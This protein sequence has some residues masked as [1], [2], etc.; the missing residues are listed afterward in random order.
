VVS[1]PAE[2]N[3][4]SMSLYQKWT[5]VLNFFELLACIV[6]FANWKKIK[7]TYWKWFPVYLAVIVSTEI[8][9]E[10]IGNIL[11]RKD[12]NAHIYYFFSI[13]L[14]FIF[15]FWLFLRWSDSGKEKKWP[16][17][18]GAI[19]VGAWLVEL[20]FLQESQLAFLSFSYTIGNIVLL[21]LILKFFI[22]FINSDRILGYRSEAMFWVCL[23][24]LIFYLMTLPFFG[25]WNTMNY[26]YPDFFNKYWI[27]QMAL[28]CLMYLLFALAFI[29]G[30]WKQRSS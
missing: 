15:F 17:I 13:P 14:Q 26:K 2:I 20:L 25:L 3:L 29:L 27:V 22:N 12:I 1:L 24:L 10:Y 21:L 16:L 7:A 5:I 6:G 28:D 19:Y 8:V 18:G 11:K 9:A 4:F 30:K 23:G